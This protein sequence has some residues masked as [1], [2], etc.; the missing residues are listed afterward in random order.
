MSE[1]I[2]S[3]TAGGLSR[4]SASAAFSGLVDEFWKAAPRSRND[5]ALCA[6][7]WVAVTRMLVRGELTGELQD[8]LQARCWE[9]AKQ[10][11]LP[12]DIHGLLW[13]A[14]D[15]GGASERTRLRALGLVSESF[16]ESGLGELDLHDVIGEYAD[17][18]GLGYDAGLCDTLIETLE[19]PAGS[20]VWIP[21][22]PSGQLAVRALRRGLRVVVSGPA[23]NHWSQS[24]V[25][26]LALIEG[27]YGLLDL[28]EDDMAAHG[29][30]PLRSVDYL[31]A[32]PPI[33]VKLMQ[34]AGWRKWEGVELGLPGSDSIYRPMLDR[35]TVQLDRSESWAVA[36]FWPYVE[37][38]AVFLTS[39]NVLF[40]KGQEQRL[41]EFLILGSSQPAAVISLPPR[42][43]NGSGVVTAITVLDRRQKSF[44]VRMVDAAAATIETK[45]TMKFSRALDSRRVTELLTS[46][47]EV[48]DVSRT[49]GLDEI[50][51]ND[52][53]LMPARYIS[54]PSLDA[55]YRVP[56]G[57]LVETVVRAPVA[58][59]EAS[60]VEVQE[61][62]I[63]DLDQW[64][65]LFGPFLRTTNIQARKLEECRLRR[66]DILVSV[67]GTLGKVGM[68]LD[69]GV[70]DSEKAELH[71]V[72]A[73]SVVALRVRTDRVSVVSL[74]LYLRSDDFKNQLTAFRTGVAQAHVTPSS[75][76]RDVKIPLRSLPEQQAAESLYYELCQLEEQ[77]KRAQSRMEEIRLGL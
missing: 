65:G 27:K 76:L 41:R 34:G 43:I 71:S 46:P 74:Y 20:K 13:P 60:A 3:R 75:L 49:I 21:F 32:C 16:A 44:G 40:A 70:R 9:E 53:G 64:G 30:P 63:A 33:G 39:P 68:F 36:A 45:S 1:N 50:I 72:C 51:A 4:A 47:G 6:L 62:G 55:E 73:Q 54:P 8:L 19:A 77:V 58:S 5:A 11:G 28:N 57:E 61:V 12:E 42:L 7:G 22:D 24:V 48:P 26:L 18:L 29:L 35:H 37:K 52:F 66:N 56:L 15:A 10:L 31:L 67:K 59:K 17:T 69:D 23:R 14:E 2:N 25:R 38:R